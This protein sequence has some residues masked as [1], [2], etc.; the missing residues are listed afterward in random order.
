[1]NTVKPL[2]DWSLPPLQKKPF[3]FLIK[4]YVPVL[5]FSSLLGTYLDLF[6]VGKHLY[7]F[8]HRPFPAT[9]SIN[10]LFTL[11]G[12]PFGTFLYLFFTKKR[13]RLIKAAILF[14]FSLVMTALE[15]KSED[16]GLFSHSRSWSH[17]YTFIGYCL[18]LIV[19][20]RFQV[21]VTLRN[22]N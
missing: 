8:P 18:Y 19:V 10:L 16:L 1:M 14:S 9:F 22:K 17:C 2:N 11:F 20:D 6:M 3:L 21:W 15:K 7:S 13:T 4:S 5:L 12:L